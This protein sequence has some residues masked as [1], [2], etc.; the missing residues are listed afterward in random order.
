MLK[1][2][3]YSAHLHA[4][5]NLWKFY[6]QQPCCFLLWIRLATCQSCSQSLSI[7]SILSVIVLFIEPDVALVILL[8]FLFAG[9]KHHELCTFQPETLVFLAVSFS[10]LRLNVFRCRR[11]A[12]LAAG[13]G[14]FIDANG[15]SGAGRSVIAAADS[16]GQQ[17]PDQMFGSCLCRFTGTR[18]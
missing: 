2:L 7:L 3:L 10:L 18:A 14:K 11:Y 6:L 5:T 12:G 16:F 4:K 8:L 17:N 1:F 15:H 9:Q 13:E